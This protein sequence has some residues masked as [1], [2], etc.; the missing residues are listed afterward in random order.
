MAMNSVSR[1]QERQERL[2]NILTILIA[3]ECRTTNTLFR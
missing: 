3:C 2:C 1:K